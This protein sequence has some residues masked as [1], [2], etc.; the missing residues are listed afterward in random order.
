MEVRETSLEGARRE[1]WE[2]ACAEI[3]IDGLLA[4]YNI[5]SN[6]QVQLIYRA[7]LVSPAVQAGPESAEVG[8][9]LWDEIPWSD[10]AF[11]SVRW[12]LLHHREA[13][14]EKS[15]TT[16]TNPEGELGEY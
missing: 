9:F 4:V 14:A 3:E 11:P 2:E 10:L 8:L 6:S 13:S 5:P 7:R 12:A 16:R 1:A 15:F